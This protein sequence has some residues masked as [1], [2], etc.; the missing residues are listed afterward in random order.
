MAY[1][2]IYNEIVLFGRRNRDSVDYYVAESTNKSHLSTGKEWSRTYD[3]EN[4]KN[5]EGLEIHTENKGFT[6]SL[7]KA[8]DY[9]SQ[10]GKLSFWMC[11]IQKGDEI[12]GDIGIN[13]HELNELIKE[14]T[15]VNGVCQQEVCFYRTGG[16]VGACVVGGERYNKL[17]NITKADDNIAKA[18]KTTKWKLGEVYLSKTYQGIWIGDVYNPITKETFHVV[19]N[20][21]I[22]NN[23][24]MKYATEYYLPRL[25]YGRMNVDYNEEEYYCYSDLYKKFPSRVSTNHYVDVSTFEDRWNQEVRQNMLDEIES[26]VERKNDYNKQLKEYPSRK[27]NAYDLRYI[28]GM[29][30]YVNKNTYP[31]DIL[32][33]YLIAAYIANVYEKYSPF[34]YDRR[35]DR[36]RHEAIPKWIFDICEDFG[37]DFEEVKKK[38]TFEYIDELEAKCK[39]WRKENE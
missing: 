23:K 32:K 29:C 35:R 16:N 28:E 3:Y 33:D 14:S 21:W 10:G 27:F 30:M 31:V 26:L 17:L 38:S 36:R 39:I 9:S 18:K 25:Y 2:R 34:S 5:I 1:C 7:D 19:N 13:Q 4:E 6:L 15:F 37:I 22:D 12:D 20:Q 24:D 11:R 8:A